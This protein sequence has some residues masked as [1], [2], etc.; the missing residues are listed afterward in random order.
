MNVLQHMKKAAIT[1]FGPMIANFE[2]KHAASAAP[3]G[4]YLP[5]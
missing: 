2:A 3:Y 1:A 5:P 4:G